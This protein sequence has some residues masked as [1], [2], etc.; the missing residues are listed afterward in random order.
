[1][2]DY[3]KRKDLDVLKYDNCIENAVQ[4]RVYAF[5]WYLDIVADNWDVL[6]LN[7]YE[8]VMPIPWKQKYFI[9]YATQPLWV[10]ELGIF[11]L[12]KKI[13]LTL[14]SERLFDQ[15]R[16]SELRLNSD[17]YSNKSNEFLIE[18]Q[19]QVL[20]LDLEYEAILENYKKDRKKDLKRAEKQ[21]L[22]ENWN[23]KPENLITLFKNNVGKRTPNILAKDYINLQRLITVCID[24]N[25]G[26]ILSV[27]NVNKKLVASG[28]LLKYN[29]SVTILVSSTDFK[30]RKNGANTF[31]IDNAIFKYQKNYK[32]FNFGG[33]SMPS[34]AKYF[35]SFGANTEKYQQIKHNKLPFLLRLFKK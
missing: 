15:F 31:L 35:L 11:S 17:N 12:E 7:D 30:N 2:I 13:N 5:S 23:D 19:F 26:E 32:L 24:K 27:Y 29:N 22:I 6:V 9:K 8:A 20:S 10:L 34:V 25:V 14:F 21:D 28:F 18:K 3:I 33:S 16:F 4:S 1:M